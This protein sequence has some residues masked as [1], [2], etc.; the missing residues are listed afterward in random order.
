M[1][2]EKLGRLVI[3]SFHVEDMVFS[4][5]PSFTEGILG[6]NKNMDITSDLISR[7][8]VEIVKPSDPDRY[9]NTIMDFIP[10]SAKVLGRL[11]EGITH[12]FT[13]F[14]VMVT[15]CDEDGRQ[16][17]EFGSSE[18]MLSNAFM[19]EKAGTPG[20]NDIIIHLDMVVRGGLPYE[21]KLPMAI[22]KEA[23]NYIDGLRAILKNQEGTSFDE[24]HEYFDLR[25][26]GGKKVVIIKQIAGQGAMYDN[27]FFP[28]EPSGA[29]GISIIDMESM[30][31]VL[32][33][34]EYRD[35]ALRAMV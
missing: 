4:Q 22:F 6:I 19:R 26:E 25:R 3:K 7:S 21:R 20:V 10:V 18:G 16:M 28:S 33:P 24:Q 12:T 17:H 29:D 32:T 27:M 23:D 8:S 14:Y 1:K 9:I 15:G 30:P 13:G 35:G 2:E 5:V 11:G 31:Q 34:N